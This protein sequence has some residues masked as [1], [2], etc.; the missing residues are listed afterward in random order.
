MVSKVFFEISLQEGYSWS[1]NFE[2]DVSIEIS[3]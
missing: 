1:G 3:L 2:V